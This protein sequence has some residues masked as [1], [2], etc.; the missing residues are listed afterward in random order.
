MH[1]DINVEESVK[2][3]VQTYLTKLPNGLCAIRAFEVIPDDKEF[4][5]HHR[6]CP[7]NQD[8]AKL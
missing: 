5:I 6:Q 2:H 8:G 7:S 1:F 4:R 3:E